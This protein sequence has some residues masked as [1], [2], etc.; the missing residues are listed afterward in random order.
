MAA[1]R[2]QRYYTPEE[3]LALERQAEY[4][5]EYING[6]IVQMTGTSTAHNEII[7]NLTQILGPQIRGRGCKGYINDQR[8]K[9]R[10]EQVYTYPDLAI[11]C[12]EVQV[13]DT[14]RDTILNPTLII[15]VLSPSTEKYD[16]G[17]KFD[18]YRQIPTL[19][20]Y[21]LIAQDQVRIDH[22][23]R[24]DNRWIFS[25]TTDPG[26]TVELPSIKCQLPVAEV[27]SDVI[28]PPEDT[29]I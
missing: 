22:F 13:E 1:P 25:A 14:H 11:V 26:T 7:W 18:Y 12:G 15:E 4:K 19:V 27:Y 28:L 16:R 20:E 8:I 2:I 3:Y 29:G 5:S 24:E 6:E 9:V 23:V 21:V 17:A 10:T